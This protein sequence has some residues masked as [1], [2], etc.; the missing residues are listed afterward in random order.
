MAS[1]FIGSRVGVAYVTLTLDNTGLKKGFTEAIAASNGFGQKMQATGAGLQALGSSMTKYVSFPLAAIGAASV[2][3]ASDFDTAMT[4]VVALSGVPAK[5]LEEYRTRILKLSHATGIAATDL[6]DTLYYVAS[7][8]LKTSQIL[9]VVQD[10]AKGAAIGMGD[11]ADLGGVLTSVMNA[12]AASGIKASQIMNTLTAA[13]RAGKAEPD[14]FATSIGAVIPVAAQMGV[15]FDQVAAALA[16]ATNYGVDTRR[17][18]TGLRYLLTSLSN[19]TDAAKEV[20]GDYGLTVGGIAKSLQKPDGL[21]STLKMLA[22]NFD[23]NT[24]KGREAWNTVIGGVR[25]TIVAN[26]AVGQNF[27]RTQKIFEETQAAIK[28]VGDNF[29]QAA[30]KVQKATPGFQFRKMWNDVKLV[31]VAIGET[32]LP[33]IQAVVTWLDKAVSGFQTLSPAMQDIVSKGIL[34]GVALGPGLKILGLLTSGWGRLISLMGKIGGGAIKAAEDAPLIAAGTALTTSAGGLGS[35]AVALD[36]SAAALQAAAEALGLGA[37]T[38][39]AL[40]N[41]GLTMEQLVARGAAQSV[42]ANPLIPA[43]NPATFAL[44]GANPAVFG[45]QFTVAEAE[46]A[47]Y[48]AQAEA[49]ATA[50]AATRATQV[51]ALQAIARGESAGVGAVAA[52][53]APAV[54]PVAAGGTGSAL[55]AGAGSIATAGALT[56]LSALAVGAFSKLADDWHETTGSLAHDTKLTVE[57][58]NALQDQFFHSASWLSPFRSETDF[59]TEASKRYRDVLD[60]ATSSGMSLYDAQTKL[61]AAWRTAVGETGG[62]TGS[63]DRFQ[64]TLE[65]SVGLAKSPELQDFMGFIS[66]QAQPTPAQITIGGTVV[67]PAGGT[68]AAR[69]AF[70]SQYLPEAAAG[71]QIDTAALTARYDRRTAALGKHMV[72]GPELAAA[73]A[74]M[75]SRAAALEDFA[76]RANSALQGMVGA[77]VPRAKALDSVLNGILVA[78]RRGVISFRDYRDILQ[79]FGQQMPYKEAGIFQQV[80]TESPYVTAKNRKETL[81]LAQ[82]MA[83]LGIKLTEDQGKYATW[84][85]AQG[86]ALSQDQV[87]GSYLRGPLK[88]I[89]KAHADDLSKGREETIRQ[90]LATGRYTGALMRLS[91]WLDKVKGKHTGSLDFKVHAPVFNKRLEGGAVG[92]NGNVLDRGVPTHMSPFTEAPDLGLNDEPAKRKVR[93]F[94]AWLKGQPPPHLAVEADTDPARRQIDAFVRSQHQQ[95]VIDIVT[96]PGRGGPSGGGSGGNNGGRGNNNGGSGGGDHRHPNQHHFGTLW[97]DEGMAR[98]Q[99]GEVVTSRSRSAKYRS[100]LG[101]IHGDNLGQLTPYMR[102]SGSRRS[103][104]SLSSGDLRELER[105]VARGMAKSGGSGDVY[106]DGYK[107]GR[108]LENRARRKVRQ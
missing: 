86:Q 85:V 45:R 15:T 34:I 64:Q 11:A 9:P 7:A 61:N 108:V 66:G 77:G 104:G 73:T 35:S 13:I 90:M 55:L 4:K 82:A 67:T 100:V 44:Q 80:L 99:G 87:F 65:T 12:Y 52:S 76:N 54:A 97:A 32:L 68:K 10:A 88:S 59:V 24:V 95:V 40:P 93:E 84:R 106:L 23:L 21:L 50:Q 96:R 49:T 27:A 75:E 18:V 19:P 2:K 56:G 29:E 101:A 14:E 83:D 42:G 102:S 41:A 105:A 30:Y 25:G 20:L 47:A 22:D 74:D 5:S 31:G 70:L 51:S 81:G 1:E 69:Q 3:M 72:A 39:K 94:H 26:T 89:L 37:L 36:V 78:A 53:A 103:G 8:G 71:P 91:K 57:Q 17:A 60:Q 58:V 6:A 28:G 62:I 33:N 46:A 63:L 107:V 79:Q 98:L 16:N 48:A 43:A 38:G 92:P